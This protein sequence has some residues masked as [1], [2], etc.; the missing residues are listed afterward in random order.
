MPHGQLTLLLEDVHERGGDVALLLGM[1]KRH[2]RMSGAVGIPE[3][4]CGIVSKIALMHLTISP[5][6]AASDVAEYRGCRHRVIEGSIED[7]THVGIIGIDGYLAKFV[8]PS[9]VGS[10]HRRFEIPTGDFGLQVGLGIL[11]ADSREG[12]LHHNRL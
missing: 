8:V 12:A 3:R 10:R 6:I 9:L 5:A 11:D 4:E 2:Q 7:G 1:D